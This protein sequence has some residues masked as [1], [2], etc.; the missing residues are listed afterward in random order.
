MWVSQRVQEGRR[1]KNEGGVIKFEWMCH[2]CTDIIYSSHQAFRAHMKLHY[3]KLF[4]GEG[5][6][7]LIDMLIEEMGRDNDKDN[8]SIVKNENKAMG[9]NELIFP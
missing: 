7:E 5:D 1:E 3:N 4:N 8:D 6:K 2:M 9:K